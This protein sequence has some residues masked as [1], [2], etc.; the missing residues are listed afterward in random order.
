MSG[1]IQIRVKINQDCASFLDIICFCLIFICLFLFSFAV[2][3]LSNIASCIQLDLA[4]HR[5]ELLP[6]ILHHFAT[7]VI[8]FQ[9]Y[10]TKLVSEFNK[11]SK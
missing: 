5:L 9:I 10:T 1:T 7:I 2:D 8:F 11:G 4:N 3:T 6:L